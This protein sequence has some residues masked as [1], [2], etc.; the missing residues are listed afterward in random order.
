MNN[1]KV[2]QLATVCIAFLATPLLTQ[3][4]QAPRA[5]AP[6]PPELQHLEEGEAPSITIRKPE[7]GQGN[8]TEKREQGRVTEIKVQK[9]GS[10]YYLKPQQVVGTSVPGD[11]P[12]SPARGAQWQVKEFDLGQKQRKEGVDEQTNAK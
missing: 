12:S 6:P 10:T 7:G 4:Q 2:W 11:T 9:G 5:S 3:A 8:I 1:S